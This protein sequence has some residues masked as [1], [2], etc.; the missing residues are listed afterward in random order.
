MPPP[1]QVLY[2]NL[3]LSKKLCS[4][5]VH[6][7]V[8]RAD[9]ET[10]VSAHPP[11]E[12]MSIGLLTD[13]VTRRR[14]AEQ[15]HQVGCSA[16]CPELLTVHDIVVPFLRRCPKRSVSLPLVGSV[17]PRLEAWLAEAM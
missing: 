1:R 2:G 14:A 17:T 10:S 15:D 13:L 9:G 6:P 11:E 8:D 7:P 5:V 12:R 4:R 16:R 3:R